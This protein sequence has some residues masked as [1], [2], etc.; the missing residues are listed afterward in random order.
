MQPPLP[1]P[2]CRG[3]Q[4]ETGRNWCSLTE[5]QTKG[6]STTTIQIRGIHKT[7]PQN[8]AALHDRH[9]TL[10]SLERVPATQLSPPA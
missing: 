7:N 10:P 2:G 5:Q 8:R 9:H 1:P 6:T 3:E 4:K